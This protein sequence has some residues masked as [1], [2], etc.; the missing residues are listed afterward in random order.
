VN[1]NKKLSVKY[2]KLTNRYI[3]THTSLVVNEHSFFFITTPIPAQ[4]GLKQPSEI[5]NE[6]R[7]DLRFGMASYSCW[8]QFGCG[9]N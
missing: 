4:L 7:A 1:P 9:E 6:D 8:K 5:T 3:F 2:K